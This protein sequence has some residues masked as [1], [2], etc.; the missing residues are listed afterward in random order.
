MEDHAICFIETGS[1]EECVK[2]GSAVKDWAPS[3]NVFE[4]EVCQGVEKVVRRKFVVVIG[5]DRV[6][7]SDSTSSIVGLLLRWLDC[8]DWLRSCKRLW[9]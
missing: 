6:S 1:A 3:I 2:S 8:W 9:C 5:W 4:V 7:E